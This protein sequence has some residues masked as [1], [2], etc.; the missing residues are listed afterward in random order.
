MASTNA[1]E[2][3]RVLYEVNLA[4]DSDVEKEFLVWLSHHMDDM[5]KLEGC[6]LSAQCFKQQMSPE[7]QAK[8]PNKVHFTVHY[9]S[10]NM[11]CLQTYFDKYAA[12]LRGDAL[13][14][15]EGKFS[16]TRRIF[17]SLKTQ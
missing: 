13:K 14:R 6:F 2:Q 5:L 4:V 15:F 12:L 1:V 16:A 7:E 3:A 8:E 10:A 17:E 9:R 11:D